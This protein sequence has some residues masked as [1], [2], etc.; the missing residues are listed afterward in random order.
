R[1]ATLG[2]FICGGS[3]GVGSITWGGLRDRGNVLGARVLTMEASPRALE[4]RGDDVRRVI[5]AYGTTGIVT[6]VEIA[7][8]A[9][10]LWIDAAVAFADFA[11]AA[12]FAYALACQDALLKKLVSVLA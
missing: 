6:E 3:G 4:L 2:G 10:P 1:T 8:A 9:A 11:A 5:H 12:R 7:L